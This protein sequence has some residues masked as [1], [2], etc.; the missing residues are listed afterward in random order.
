MTRGLPNADAVPVAVLGGGLAGLNVA[1]ELQGA[2]I[3]F[4]LFEARDRLGGRILTL[5]ENGQP[6]EDGF[7]LGPSWFWPDMQPKLARRVAELGLRTMMQHTAGDMLYESGPHQAPERVRQLADQNSARI[8]GGMGAL[9]RALEKGLH[10][11][12][13][14]L[15]A[16]VTM[17]T[18]GRD[19]VQMTVAR[20]GNPPETLLARHVISTLPP[21]LMA[22]N[23]H[24]DPAPPI[25]LRRH[26]QDTPTWMAPHAKFVAVYGEAFW[27]TDGLSGA[28]QSRVGPLV[29]IHDATTA[30]GKAALFGFVGLSAKSRATMRQDELIRAALAQLEHLF[31]PKA[32]N[33]RAT[34]LKDWAT[35]RFTAAEADDPRSGH[36]Q[37]S[38]KPWVVEPWAERLTFAGSET[39]L[40][41]PGYLAGAI[42]ASSRTAQDWMRSDALRVDDADSPSH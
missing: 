24:L 33:P 20:Q 2:G 18:L 19:A 35:D 37:V 1:H 25:A 17:L 13:L 40:T 11:Q 15:S 29:E 42:E 14:S 7:D 9:V 3:P 22:Q 38:P 8:V 23:L 4:H 36:P 32:G 21:R 30:S 39:S 10:L 28:A 41:E 12:S 5:G 6:S 27:R 34:L 26:W 16:E 31:G